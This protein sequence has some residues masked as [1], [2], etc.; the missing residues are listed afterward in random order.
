MP[1]CQEPLDNNTHSFVEG[2]PSNPHQ[3]TMAH[4]SASLFYGKDAPFMKKFAR[5]LDDD[6]W[7]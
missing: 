7:D 4:P 2:V 1:L 3:R 5:Y 6:L